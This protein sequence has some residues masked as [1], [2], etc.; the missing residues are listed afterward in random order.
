MNRE[1]RLVDERRIKCY[2]K[3]GGEELPE[4][5]FRTSCK[6][7]AL[8]EIIAVTQELVCNPGSGFECGHKRT[9]L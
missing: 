3:D 5:E 8:Q 6:R 4:R 7:G 2:V 9:Y 1:P